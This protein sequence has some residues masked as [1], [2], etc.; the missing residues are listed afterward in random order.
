MK[1]L[2][3]AAVAGLAILVATLI[4]LAK[5]HVHDETE[6]LENLRASIR[7]S[8]I[9]C[10][11]AVDPDLH[12][13][14]TARSQEHSEP[15]LKALAQLDAAKSAC[16]GPE[17]F[18]YVYTAIL[19]NGSPH[20][21]LD[22]A[23]EGDS[24]HDGVDDKAHIMQPFPDAPPQLLECFTSGV[25]TVT[26]KPWKD[27]W[28]T[29]QTGFAPIKDSSGKVIAVV[30]LDMDLSDFEHHVDDIHRNSLTIGLGALSMA[31][32]AGV[33][34]WTYHQKLSSSIAVLLNATE[35]ARAADRA[36]SEFLAT[37][38]HEIR[39][40]MNGVIGM[41]ELLLTTRL[42]PTQRDYVETI[43]AS[44]ESLLAILNDILDYS[45][46]EAGS[47][48]LESKPVTLE[49]VIRDVI[50]LFLPKAAEKGLALEKS[51]APTIPPVILSDPTRLRQV[52][53]NLVSN[54]V[55]FTRAGHVSL[56]LTSASTPDGSPAIRFAISDSGIGITDDQRERLFQT[57]S[58]G[59]SSTT[60]K[61]GGTGLGLAISQRI[62]NA[63]HSAIVVDSSPGHG[64]TFHFTLPIQTPPPTPSPS[65]AQPPTPAPTLTETTPPAPLAPPPSPPDILLICN[66]R[67]LRT[68]MQRRLE[69][70]GALVTTSSSLTSS[71]TPVT[72]HSLVIADLD[73]AS[74][75]PVSFAASLAASFPTSRLALFDSGLEPAQI[76]HL[77]SLGI[78]HILPRDP[79]LVSF[80]ALLHPS[81]P[82]SPHAPP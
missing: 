72:P 21:I 36:K 68:L 76:N 65:Q 71:H 64:S 66:D 43:H 78:S 31:L 13:S 60:R 16:E 61:F 70:S 62:V 17:K 5:F 7:R 82:P 37:M 57:F 9:A 67:L 23:A 2:V 11:F 49:P 10:S 41:T 45:K 79:K 53:I 58:Q 32:L 39:T 25:P 8:A 63:M 44:G 1:P 77:K 20:F 19:L 56:S 59:D 40:P 51:I 6:D 18:R 81:S 55:K 30:G 52:L 69:K 29:F 14:F 24:D 80:S 50:S 28:G 3:S 22:T 4:V 27:A 74:E 47:L 33:L 75:D 46:I 73:T 48:S 12:K 38:S 42:D 26:P 15:Y 34:V 35:D 54:A